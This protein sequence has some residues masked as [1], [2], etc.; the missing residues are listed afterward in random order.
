MTG[1][2]RD[3]LRAL[4][5]EVVREA[6]KEATAGRAVPAPAPPAPPA[7][8]KP[9]PAPTVAE[10]IGVVAAG[11]LAADGKHRTE[12][13]RLASDRDLDE[14]VRH[15]LRLFDNPKTRSDVKTGRLTFRLAGAATGARVSTHR[16]DSGAVTERHIA[17]MGATGGTLVL[18]RR[19]ILTPLAQEKARALGIAIEKERK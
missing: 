18:G 4:V 12:T 13:V 19:A 1:L 8:P 5:R 14:F 9:A 3:D 11:P 16:I 7:P 10:Q 17:D 6:V 15:L 2:N